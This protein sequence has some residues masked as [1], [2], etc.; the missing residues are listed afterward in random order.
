MTIKTGVANDHLD[1][2]NTLHTF[3]TATGHAWG[4]E[5]VGTGNGRLLG[6]DNSEGGYSGG[7]ASVAETFTIA[8]INATTF[9][10]TGSVSGALAN[11]T[12][13]VA[14]DTTK[15]K[16]KIVAGGTAFV[17]S[18]TFTLQITPPWTNERRMGALWDGAVAP[19]TSNMTNAQRL[20]DNLTTDFATLAV[21]SLPATITVELLYATE[22]RG[23][24]LGAT[25]TNAGTLNRSPGA[26][27]IAYSDNG[28]SWTTHQ[29]WSGITW[30]AAGTTQ[31]F[32]FDSAPGAHKYWRLTITALAAGGGTQLEC[33]EFDL[34][35][36]A[37]SLNNWMPSDRN[38][39][40]Y[41][42]TG[43]D[44]TKEI[45]FAYSIRQ[46]A[47]A[48]YWNLIFKGFRFW[49]PNRTTLDQ[50]ASHNGTVVLPLINQ[51]FTY[52]MVA[53]GQRTILVARI[54]A[55]YHTAYLGFGLPYETPTNHP[56]PCIFAA[57]SHSE[58]VLSSNN[59]ALVRFPIDPVVGNSTNLA[60]CWAF[61]PNSE[62]VRVGNRT[63]VATVEGG[64]ANANN[65]DRALVWPLS[66]DYEGVAASTRREGLDGTPPIFPAV[67][68]YHNLQITTRPEDRFHTWGE[69]D[70]LYAVYGLNIAAQNEL[71]FGPHKY[72]V[73]PNIFRSSTYHYAALR[74]D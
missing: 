72:L 62:W 51:P 70:G 16:F 22:I 13:G 40:V 56:Y 32:Y 11:A 5:Y 10:V 73:I 57:S 74:M 24:R 33:C 35:K 6:I 23:F 31:E 9:S 52:W 37:V 48:G 3:L 61:F 26:F 69:F 58:T 42:A 66:L 55:V 21:G 18:D 50:A 49:N 59:T 63:D 60:S 45:Y 41:K 44:N 36:N 38:E 71:S 65:Y 25:G 27:S 47:G 12:V 17:A 53:N 43:L 39:L 34:L 20:Y 54:G 14:Y 67:I 64:N 46:D 19:Y 4:K 1:F 28:S 30:T 29:S 15:V 68:I 7:S 8:A 2:C